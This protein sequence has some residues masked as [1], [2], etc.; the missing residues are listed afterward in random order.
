MSTTRGVL[1]FNA[2]TVQVLLTQQ[3]D[4]VIIGTAVVDL[5]D[6][7]RKS[8]EPPLR[9]LAPTAKEA[10]SQLAALI[11]RVVSVAGAALLLLVISSCA[12]PPRVACSGSAPI[13]CEC[14]TTCDVTDAGVITTDPPLWRVTATNGCVGRCWDRSRGGP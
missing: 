1:R 11:G 9:V 3:S 10:W 8:A 13:T 2:A 5:H 6:H 12:P 14:V 7:E 4:G